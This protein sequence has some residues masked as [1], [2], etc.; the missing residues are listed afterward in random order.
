MNLTMIARCC[1]QSVGLPYGF[2]SAAKRRKTTQR[3]ANTRKQV[4]ENPWTGVIPSF[5]RYPV[6]VHAIP[7]A[8]I[9]L[10]NGQVALVDE[11]DLP[12]VSRWKW[13]VDGGGY[14]RRNTKGPDRRSRSIYMHRVIMDEPPGL[15]ID[16]INGNR[17][18]NRRDNLLAVP[19][20][21]SLWNRRAPAKGITRAKNGAWRAF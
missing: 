17:L 19:H 21:Q 6:S 9:K 14:A 7:M 3:S 16:H 5:L 2:G 4:V 12:K 10:A 8:E 1:G 18:D 15:D 11:A 13:H 20:V